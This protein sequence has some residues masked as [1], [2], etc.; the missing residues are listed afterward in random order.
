MKSQKIKGITFK[1]LGNPAFSIETP[2]QHI[3][4]NTLL[5]AVAKKQSGKTYFITNLMRMLSFDIVIVVSNTFDSN[6]RMM[7]ALKVEF[8]LDPDDPNVIQKI[9]DFINNERDELMIYQ[10]KMKQYKE[11]EKMLKNPDRMIPDEVL[12]QFFNGNEFVKPEHRF[13]GRKPSIGIFIDDAQNSKI[14]GGK[15]SNLCIKHRHLGS[16]PD[17]SRP[18]GCSLFIAVQNYVSSNNGLPKAIRGNVS[19]LAVWKTGNKKELELL[20]KEQS[21]NVSEEDFYKAYNF[22]FDNPNA[23]KHDFLFID[24]APKEGHSTFRKNYDEMIII[25]DK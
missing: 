16:F 6:K 5:L 24:L 14:M 23:S 22:V 9:I 1:D 2:P 21:G 25:D 7:E 13:N 12:E 19:H 8:V 4:L 10:E 11:F 15:L 18:L 17:G 20:A 3:K